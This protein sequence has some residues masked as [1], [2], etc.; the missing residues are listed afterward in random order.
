MPTIPI[1]SLVSVEDANV[2]ATQIIAGGK[3]S[4]KKRILPQSF[5]LASSIADIRQNDTI[6]GSST[7]EIDVIDR[8]W[9]LID[10]HFLDAD[11]DGKLEPT[12]DINYPLGSQYWWRLTTVDVSDDP[13]TANITLTFMERVV[14][15]MIDKK[16]TAIK[17]SRNQMTR[18]QFIK[19]LVHIADKQAH[20]V[21]TQLTAKQP[22]EPIPKDKDTSRNEKDNGIGFDDDSLTVKG[23]TI[24]TD[25]IKR[26][27]TILGVAQDLKARPRAIKGMMCAAIGESALGED[28]GAR[29]TTFQ[30]YAFSESDLAGQAKAFLTG[31]KSF[32]AGGAMKAAREHPD[33]SVGTIASKV[34]VSDKG[35]DFYDSNAD[36][37]GAII[38]AYGMP[39]VTDNPDYIKQ[40]NYTK[41]KGDDNWMTATNLAD[42]VQWYL[43][44]NGN[45]VHYDTGDVLIKQKPI[46]VLHRGDSDIISIRFK[47]DSRKIATNM[48]IEMFCD[49][50]DYRAGEVFK[51]I[52]F[53]SA[54][55]GKHKGCWLISEIDGS[56]FAPS[57]TFTLVQPKK[58]K[59]E[60]SSEPGTRD[61]SSSDVNENQLVFPLPEDANLSDLGGVAAHKARPFGNWQSDNAVDIGCPLGT[62]V[63]AVADGKITQLGGH[64]DG[65]GNSNPNGYN[66][67]LDISGPGSIW[68]Y[69]HLRYRKPLQIGDT[70]K[71]G[72]FLGSS[73]AANGVPHLHIGSKTGD[74]EA[75][76][77]VKEVAS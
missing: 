17:I 13:S 65:T 35:G 43:F 36:E 12:I 28:T 39:D 14:V 46:K 59:K 18:A 9:V 48:T 30:T 31:G 26:A 1:T 22:R 69:T 3:K 62:A 6:E 42:E 51:F 70:V 15:R 2:V 5:D 24:N 77:K 29:G 49:P 53:G 4:K 63:Y 67:T 37:A 74:P 58:K 57:R 68:W 21:C 20:F 7:L 10:S 76:L 16:G 8:E 66:I 56:R 55:M 44:V 54:S 52:G 61:D 19:H 60:P 72:E 45:Y 32:G 38:Q 64:W 73:G 25:Q 34:E 75:L 47:W 33:W 40:F 23:V 27:N 71:A 50:D 41:A 11:E